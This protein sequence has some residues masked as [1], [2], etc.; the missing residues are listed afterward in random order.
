MAGLLPKRPASQGPLHVALVNAG[1]LPYK[2]RAQS[3]HVGDPARL[4]L[5]VGHCC[6]RGVR[7]PFGQYEPAGVAHQ[8]SSTDN[9]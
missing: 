3:V 2:P 9:G 7:V 8:R 1:V 6:K 4:Y 5:P